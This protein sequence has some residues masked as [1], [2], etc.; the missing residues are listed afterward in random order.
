MTIDRR[1]DRGSIVDT[2]GGRTTR[3]SGPLARIRS[4]RPLSASVR[5]Q[6]DPGP[7]MHRG[8]EYAS[9]GGPRD[10]RLAKRA[11]VSAS[12]RSVLASSLRPSTRS[13]PTNYSAVNSMLRKLSSVA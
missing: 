1:S 10:N 12:I 8:Y 6:G 13:P 9:N 3:V 7:Q 4:P 2:T 5:E 11:S